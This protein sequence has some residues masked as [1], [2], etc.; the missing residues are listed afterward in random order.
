MIL[1]Q[2]YSG[3]GYKPNQGSYLA[4]IPLNIKQRKHREGPLSNVRGISDPEQ[5]NKG[6]GEPEQGER[7][8]FV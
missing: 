7:L 6:V 2:E 5:I 1:V 3:S 8:S 4:L